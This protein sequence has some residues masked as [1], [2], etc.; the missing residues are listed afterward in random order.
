VP[1]ALRPRRAVQGRQPD[2]H[3]LPHVDFDVDRALGNALEVNPRIT[4]FRVSARTGE[5]L[6]GWYA[7]I[8]LQRSAARHPGASPQR[9]IP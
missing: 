8:R 2:G 1:G 7:W 9:R 6:E 4:A 5:G 3:R